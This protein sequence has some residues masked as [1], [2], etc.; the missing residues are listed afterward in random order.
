MADNNRQ[1]ENG[2]EVISNFENTG[3]SMTC[4]LCKNLESQLPDVLNEL[5]SVHLIVDLLSKETNWVQSESLIYTSVTKQW[6]QAP[7]ILQKT[8]AHQKSLKTTDRILYQHISET[9]NH[10]ETLTNLSTDLAIT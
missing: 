4:E 7:Y 8:P 1:T 3:N 2:A 9:T 6:T 5:L 10:F